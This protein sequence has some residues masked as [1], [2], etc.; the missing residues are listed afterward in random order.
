MWWM[1][2]LWGTTARILERSCDEIEQQEGHA[3]SE[4]WSGSASPVARL[5]GAVL[6]FQK[7][8]LFALYLV[9]SLGHVPRIQ[10]LDLRERLR[11]YPGHKARSH[12]Q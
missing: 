1:L 7:S 12:Y 2:C 9:S 10:M 4:V 3:G 8:R 6:S 11:V 5:H